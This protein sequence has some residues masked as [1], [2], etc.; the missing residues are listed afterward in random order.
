MKGAPHQLSHITE[1]FIEAALA[2]GRQIMAAA[3]CGSTMKAD[4]SPVTDADL[5]AEAIIR[6]KLTAALP[7]IP[8]IGEEHGSTCTPGT[9]P[10]A[11]ILVDPLDG[12]RDF[13]A[14]SPEFTVNIALISQGRA[15][16]GVVHAPALGRLFAGE[17]GASARE[18]AV[19]REGAVDTMGGRPIAVRK[20]VGDG[21]VALESRSHREPAT[22]ALLAQFRPATRRRVGSSLKFAL[23]AAG[24]G[25]LYVRGVS[26]NGWDIAAGDALL[27]AAGGAVRSL[28]GEPIR[29][30]PDAAKAPPFIASGDPRLQGSIGEPRPAT[31]R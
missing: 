20:V 14:G 28:A 10:D 1:L 2:A 12:T 30:G 29:Y 9:V 31:M 5:R 15:V 18:I 16:V 22:E 8:V 25:D 3:G 17:V 6:E 24:E 27:T 19:S 21:P 4:R 26:L 7:D 23:I 13:L 11:L